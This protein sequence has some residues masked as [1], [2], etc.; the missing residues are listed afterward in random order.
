MTVRLVT[1]YAAPYALVTRNGVSPGKRPNT[2]LAFLTEAVAEKGQ[3]IG[4]RGRIAT[5][6]AMS[7]WS[8]T[9]RPIDAEEVITTWRS[10]PSLA[11]IERE[12][13]KLKPVPPDECF[14]LADRHAIA[15]VDGKPMRA[16][17]Q[18]VV[19]R[20]PNARRFSA[21]EWSEGRPGA[22]VYL[23]PASIVFRWPDIA[24]FNPVERER[25]N[26]ALRSH[27]LI[28]IGV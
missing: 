11:A 19:Q 17:L 26:S 7:D 1:S 4:F 9:I 5:D 15:V 25:V 24:Q 2:K 21:V 22:I 13:R 23:D 8:G 28:E 12:R 3:I 14:P 20:G 10:K 16:I 6:A 18:R 27:G